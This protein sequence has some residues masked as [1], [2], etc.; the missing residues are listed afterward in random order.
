M[1]YRNML[2]LAVGFVSTGIL[3]CPLMAAP[4]VKKLGVSTPSNIQNAKLIQQ[5]TSTSGQRS[6]SVRLLG[7]SAKP[8]TKPVSTTNMVNVAPSTT[9]TTDSARLSGLHG[10]LVKGI[11]SKLSSNYSQQ[12]KNT[13]T[14]D[15]TKR[16][17]ALE[18]QMTTKQTIL[19]P[20]DGIT[21]DGKTIGLSEELT[22]LP[23]KVA[24]INQEISTLSEK[25]DVANLSSNYY[26]I[27]QTQ[28]YL[29]QNYYTKTY[30]DQIISQLSNSKVVDHFDPGFLTKEQTQE[31]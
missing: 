14:S 20:G 4:T 1:L 8:V 22:I 11:S 10:N 28:E 26:T 12:Q 9:G 17:I 15:L 3:M 25:V 24:E 29:Q 21:I 6:P 13:D 19:E 18:E 7:T 31:P 23:D 30:V 27:G 2:F 5:K 16:V